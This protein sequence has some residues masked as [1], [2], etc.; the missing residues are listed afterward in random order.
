MK[1]QVKN[2]TVKAAKTVQ[3]NQVAF[4]PDDDVYAAIRKCEAGG[5]SAGQLLNECVRVYEFRAKAGV[6]QPDSLEMVYHFQ[7]RF[8]NEDNGLLADENKNLY[9]AVV[10]HHDGRDWIEDYD[11]GGWK[12]LEQADKLDLGDP[13]SIDEA[14]SWFAR[15]DEWST[16]ST[17]S[18]ALVCEMAAEALVKAYKKDALPDKKPKSDSGKQ[19]VTMTVEVDSPSYGVLAEAGIK[20]K[21]TPSEALEKFL[22]GD[23]LMDWAMK[24]F[25]L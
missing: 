2:G 18:M 10:S 4:T 1:K 23:A 15:C 6:E 24:G 17:G 14:L 7:T 9:L 8:P 11:S 12:T 20:F 25:R 21:C 16:D 3:T 13:V 19:T 5:V 22:G